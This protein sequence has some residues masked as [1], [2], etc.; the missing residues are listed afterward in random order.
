MKESCYKTVSEED[1]HPYPQAKSIY[2]NHFDILDKAE[3]DVLE[4]KFSSIRQAEL[5]AQ[6]PVLNELA[7]PDYLYSFQ[8]YTL[9]HYRLFQDLYPWAGMLRSFDMKYDFHVFTPANMLVYYGTQV[10]DDF[11]AKV[12]TGFQDRQEFIK[13]SVKFLN[14]INTLHPFPDG[15]GRSQRNIISMHLNIFRY[16]VTPESCA[17]NT[18]GFTL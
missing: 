3:L 7:L 1:L 14:L 13:E 5:L 9:I 17:I 10:F 18:G 12:E 16:T 6:L 8:T 4:R 11:K 2:A 15:N